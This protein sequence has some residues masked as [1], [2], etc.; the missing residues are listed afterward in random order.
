M[1]EPTIATSQRHQMAAGRESLRLM[2]G[3]NPTH[4]QS[5]AKNI[6]ERWLVAKV[7]ARDLSKELQNELAIYKNEMMKES[8]TSEEVERYLAY[9]LESPEK[10]EKWLAKIVEHGSMISAEKKTQK[11]ISKIEGSMP[12]PSP[13]S[14]DMILQAMNCNWDLA[15]AQLKSIAT[16]DKSGAAGKKFAIEDAI[17]VTRTLRLDGMANFQYFDILAE[18]KVELH[19]LLSNQN[20]NTVGQDELQKFTLPLHR[21][22]CRYTRQ[23]QE[24]ESK[25]EQLKELKFQQYK[26]D[27]ARTTPVA[28]SAA[29]AA[30]AATVPVAAGPRG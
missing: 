10:F 1:F 23:V 26:F 14:R 17:A 5:I 21:E 9:K 19:I 6:E 8:G 22:F 3:K 7:R 29:A 30:A 28:L 13:L 16:G 12:Q 4:W 15:L 11:K 27:K 20:L 24:K 25:L 2:I 18:R